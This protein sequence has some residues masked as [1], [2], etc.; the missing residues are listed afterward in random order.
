LSTFPGRI[1][2]E[3]AGA[4]R[5]LLSDDAVGVTGTSLPATSGRR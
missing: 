5:L 4:V 1:D 3:V 2:V